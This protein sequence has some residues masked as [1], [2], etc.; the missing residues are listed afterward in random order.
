MAET[1]QENQRIRITKRILRET[2]MALLKDNDPDHISVKELCSAAQINRSTF[3]AHYRDVQHLYNEMSDQL[4]DDLE[5]YLNESDPGVLPMLEYIQAHAEECQLL[6]YNRH[7]M[8]TSYPAQ[9]R[10]Q[11]E[12]LPMLFQVNHAPDTQDMRAALRF[13]FGGGNAVL[14]H[15]VNHGCNMPAKELADLLVRFSAQVV[16]CV[17]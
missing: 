15:W 6:L 16:L 4:V 10:I 17:D 1:M 2:M 11:N 7:F 13:A 12:V 5:S 8:D 3:Y 9:A 14:L